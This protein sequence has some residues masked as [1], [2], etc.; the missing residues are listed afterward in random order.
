MMC[1]RKAAATCFILILPALVADARVVRHYT[2][3]LFENPPRIDGRFSSSEWVRAVGFDGMKSDEVLEERAVRAFVGA[4]ETDIYVAVV[5]E[6][7]QDGAL[8]GKISS[9]TPKIMYDDTVEV[10]LNPAPSAGDNQRF[11]LIASVSG[12]SCCLARSEAGPAERPDLRA[13][14]MIEHGFSRDH[15]IA[16]FRIPIG[17]I[18]PGRGAT[19]GQWGI[20]V[21]RNWKNPWKSSSIAHP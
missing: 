18:A 1:N 10:F 16:E 19:E 15:W 5:S 9:D 4:T 8:L 2:A 20:D 14:C 3:P 11:R 12:A 13:R 7:P 21:C 17:S 6:L